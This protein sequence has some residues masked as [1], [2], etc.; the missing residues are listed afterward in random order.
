MATCTA[1]L[2]AHPLPLMPSI[3]HEKLWHAPAIYLNLLGALWL[4]Y[5]L[6]VDAQHWDGR[7]PRPAVVLTV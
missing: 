2:P 3:W 7:R 5:V 6:K 4:S 1:L